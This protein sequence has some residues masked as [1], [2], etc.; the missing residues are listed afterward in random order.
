LNEHNIRDK[1]ILRRE[2][3]KISNEISEKTGMELNTIESHMNQLA[4]V[5]V[6]NPPYLRQEAI[7]DAKK[8]YYVHTY[9]LNKKSDIYGYFMIRTLKLL[10]DNG[11]ASVITSDKWLETGYGL[12]LQVKL[13]DHIIAIYGQKERT[14]GADINTVI[15]VFSK[16]RRE[17]S[18]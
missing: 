16:E 18:L 11:I 9:G 8:S 1:N 14:F 17:M 13:K 10:Q 5:I 6:M 15:T 3:A 12:S 7:L 4:D 2:L